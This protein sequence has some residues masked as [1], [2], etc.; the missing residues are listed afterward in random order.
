MIPFSEW[1]ISVDVHR[2]CW[3]FQEREEPNATHIT[4]DAEL[5]PSLDSAKRFAE[6]FY[7]SMCE[8]DELEL[9]K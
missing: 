5:Y 9:T 8:K 3:I 4:V 1:I 6:E 7:N 2:Y